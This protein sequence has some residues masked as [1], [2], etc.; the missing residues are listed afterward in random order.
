MAESD[1]TDF[2]IREHKL[3]RLLLKFIGE[4]GS[5]KNL[6]QECHMLPWQAWPCLQI[7]TF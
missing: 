6:R 1:D 3:W 7:L 2:N 4:Q 5:G